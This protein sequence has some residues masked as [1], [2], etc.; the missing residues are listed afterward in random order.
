MLA[1]LTNRPPNSDPL[2]ARAARVALHCTKGAVLTSMAA[3]VLF[4]A[5]AVLMPSPL[6]G[7][8]SASFV[9]GEGLVVGFFVGLLLVPVWITN[10]V[11]GTLLLRRGRSRS[12]NVA[13]LVLTV[14]TAS[15]ALAGLGATEHVRVALSE[16][17]L[18]E[19]IVALFPALGIST[20]VLP[21]LFPTELARWQ[22][23][24]RETLP[25]AVDNRG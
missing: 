17:H 23:W 2:L 19:G 9:M 7:P 12:E 13:S 6:P 3:A 25:E 1:P 11:A 18:G 4:M 20:F 22:S 15:L 21:L 8:R 14:A 5:A 16:L 10:V 24:L